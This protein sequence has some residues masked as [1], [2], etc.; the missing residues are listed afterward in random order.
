MACVY[1]ST[2]EMVER[3]AEAAR[4]D[5]QSAGA[6]D[7]VEDVNFLRKKLPVYAPCTCRPTDALRE[8]AKKVLDHSK[9]VD[10]ELLRDW[11]VQLATYVH[12]LETE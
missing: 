10:A 6:M 12:K 5:T 2:K 11:A 1:C 3:L 9:T 7:L 8:I 4:K